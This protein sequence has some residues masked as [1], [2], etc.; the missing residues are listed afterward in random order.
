MKKFLSV[1]LCFLI[2]TATVFSAPAT[3]LAV[4]IVGGGYAAYVILAAALAAAGYTVATNQV[5]PEVFAGLLAAPGSEL[6]NAVI[7]STQMYANAKGQVFF[8]WT[9][10]QWAT[11]TNWV[12]TSGVVTGSVSIPGSSS[13]II[14]SSDFSVSS[15]SSY[16][17]KIPTHNGIVG[18]FIGNTSLNL[19]D[20]R[21]TA[22]LIMSEQNIYFKAINNYYYGFPSNTDHILLSEFVQ[23]TN[24]VLPHFYISVP[25]YNNSITTLSKA[26]MAVNLINT[27]FPYL[28]IGSK[29]Y[30]YSLR[31]S[32]ICLSI[33]NSYIPI[34]GTE[35]FPKVYT[36][37]I[38]WFTDV[39]NTGNLVGDLT[40][41]GIGEDVINP[42][43]PETQVSIDA[44]P[45]YQVGKGD[46]SI[47][48]VIDGTIDIPLDR[49]IDGPIDISQDPVPIDF[50]DWPDK[51]IDTT[52]DDVVPDIR[53]NPPAEVT[54]PDTPWAD[55]DS[56][57]LDYP[58]DTTA[59]PLPPG[60]NPNPDPGQDEKTN[61]LK[62]G[63]LLLSK[64]P[65]C[66][67]WDL[68][69]G[70]KVLVAPAEAPAFTVPIVN[71]RLGINTSLT[72][73]LS[74][75]DVLAK[76]CRWFFSAL[77]VVILIMITSKIVWK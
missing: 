15:L 45:D 36:S 75:A 11:F 5:S 35:L 41:L 51:T 37:V 72:I 53:L 77:W 49:W 13:S 67:P 25:G 70:L 22:N 31:G 4:E 20:S 18:T 65:F 39:I 59:D 23:L 33:N 73:D 47:P 26:N 3:G 2:L 1:L 50:T 74:F 10:E 24:D 69:H 68:M 46:L 40:G 71:E 43:Y 64:F 16:P 61:R 7:G 76:V 12:A 66:L 28:I 63:P 6:I 62:L 44:Y 54:A 14:P 57:P 21:L 55:E 8:N 32:Q 30:T 29:S 9:A 56:Y 34:T 58:I 60:N 48:D 27:T 38:E 52:P 19:V 42:A 17:D